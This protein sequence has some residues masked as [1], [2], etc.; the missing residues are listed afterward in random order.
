MLFLSD[1]MERQ[2]YDRL[3]YVAFFMGEPWESSPVNQARMRLYYFWHI[4]F[5]FYADEPELRNIY[6]PRGL[7]QRALN[8]L[9]LVEVLDEAAFKVYCWDRC[10]WNCRPMAYERID[11][12]Q[13]LVSIVKY[14][15]KRDRIRR[16]FGGDK[17]F[18]LQ[19]KDLCMWFRLLPSAFFL[20]LESLMN[21]NAMHA[22]F[23]DESCSE[24]LQWEF[25]FDATMI[26]SL[27]IGC[28]SSSVFLMIWIRQL[29][30]LL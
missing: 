26:D 23:G 22:S 4:V 15:T 1:F 5:T 14:E 6:H 16:Y 28:V 2:G 19:E 3:Q 24:E 30:V 13:A 10:Y 21:L 20:T 17:L 12:L 18:N 27:S 29:C 9:N 7:L 8:Y 25:R 11:E